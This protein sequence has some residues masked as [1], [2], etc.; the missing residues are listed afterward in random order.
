MEDTK[1]YIVSVDLT[2]LNLLFCESDETPDLPK[3]AI[4]A[5]PQNLRRQEHMR[6]GNWRSGMT[7]MLYMRAIIS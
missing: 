7:C 6:G 5:R 4:K 3:E 1:S 2:A